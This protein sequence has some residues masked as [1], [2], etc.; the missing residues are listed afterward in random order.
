VIEKLE[1]ILSEDLP[2]IGTTW[3]SLTKLNLLFKKQQTPTLW[4]LNALT[5][6]PI[7]LDPERQDDTTD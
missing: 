6:D 1:I 2:K 4:F 3:D 5:A 7:E